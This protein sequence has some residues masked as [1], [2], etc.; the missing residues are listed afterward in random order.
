TYKRVVTHVPPV[1]G[2]LII[3][4][5]VDPTRELSIDIY[6]GSCVNIIDVV[7]VIFQQHYSVYAYYEAEYR[8]R[9]GKP[10][11]SYMNHDDLVGFSHDVPMMTD[12]RRDILRAIADILR[13]SYEKRDAPRPY[14]SSHIRLES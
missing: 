4:D 2:K 11:S 3:R 8:Q 7:G 12:K 1:I 13:E 14:E 6:E 5:V 9:T 10:P